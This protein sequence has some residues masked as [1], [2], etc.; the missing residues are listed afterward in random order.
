MNAI[1]NAYTVCGQYFD[2]GQ[3]FVFHVKA[4]SPEQ[5]VLA[6]KAMVS[7]DP[8]DQDFLDSNMEILFVFLG[9]HICQSS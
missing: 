3:P 7:D 9:H 2:S 8:D 5:A 4:T 1:E 6:S